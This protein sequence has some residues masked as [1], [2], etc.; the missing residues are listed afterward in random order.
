MNCT[1]IVFST[2][3][4]VVVLAALASAV[5]A[6]SIVVGARRAQARAERARDRDLAVMAML[7]DDWAGTDRLPNP[8]SAALYTLHPDY[9]VPEGIE[10]HRPD[11]PVPQPTPRPCACADNLKGT[12]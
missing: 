10:D 2:P 12:P 3:G 6:V 1:Q 11:F 9:V 5:L 7:V 4:L 8:G